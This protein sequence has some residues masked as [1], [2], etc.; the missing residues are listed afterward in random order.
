[1]W[2]VVLSCF[3]DFYLN[4]SVFCTSQTAFTCGWKPS[5]VC[6]AVFGLKH[7]KEKWEEETIKANKKH[8][9]QLKK[10]EKKDENLKEKSKQHDPKLL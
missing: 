5:L 2:K 3:W 10:K 9:E 1:M 8:I 6:S 7:C 4:V